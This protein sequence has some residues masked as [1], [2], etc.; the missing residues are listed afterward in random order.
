MYQE[1]G[2]RGLASIE[3]SVDAPIQWL[4]DYIE[5]HKEGIITAIKNDVDNMV[6][7]RMTITRK[8]K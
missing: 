1:N 8:Q 2:G 4:D 5:K 6:S 3:D 7:N